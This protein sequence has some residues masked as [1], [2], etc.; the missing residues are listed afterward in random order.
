MI[1]SPDRVSRSQRGEAADDP[2]GQ[3]RH[4]LGVVVLH[5]HPVAAGDHHRRVRRPLLG[6][7]LM[8][9]PALDHGWRPRVQALVARP[10]PPDPRRCPTL[11]I[12]PVREVTRTVM[13]PL[14]ASGWCT[15]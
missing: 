1:V 9:I 15:K 11:W 5:P 7:A 10:G 14:P 4:V 12:R 13:L 2:A 6:V 8:M 3:A